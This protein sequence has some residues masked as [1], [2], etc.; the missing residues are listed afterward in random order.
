M[1]GS[2]DKVE[3]LLIQDFLH[4]NERRNLMQRTAFIA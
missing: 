2:N 3:I 4:D 1:L